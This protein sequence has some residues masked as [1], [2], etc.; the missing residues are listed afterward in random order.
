MSDC[1]F[2]F[3][4]LESLKFRFMNYGYKLQFSNDLKFVLTRSKRKFDTVTE[5]AKRIAKGLIGFN[6]Y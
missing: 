6:G 4:I 1:P 5:F 3:H 2:G